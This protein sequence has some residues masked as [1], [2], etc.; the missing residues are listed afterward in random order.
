MSKDIDLG[1]VF[2]PKVISDFMVNLFSDID[3][4][5]KVVLDPCF[6][7]GIFIKSLINKGFTKIRGYEI[8]TNLYRVF[9]KE[10]GDFK[11][12]KTF[13]TDF[14][15]NNNDDYYDCVVMNPPY[16]RHE[17]I[18]DLSQFG[19]TKD[20][21]RRLKIFEDL[22]SSS[23]IYM[24]FILKALSILKDNGEL[25]VIMP[26]TWIKNQHN[27]FLKSIKKHG[28]IKHM[29]FIRGSVF[30]KDALVSVSILKI[31]KTSNNYDL[32]ETK[33]EHF[34]YENNKLLQIEKI[35]Y[36]DPGDQ[37]HCS[38]EDFTFIR[39]GITT[40][41]N[42]FFFNAPLDGKSYRNMVVSPKNIVGFKTTYKS[43]SKFLYLSKT[44]KASSEVSEYL[45]ISKDE[46]LKIKKPKTIYDYIVKGRD[47]PDFSIFDK[48]CIGIIF[49]YM[50][51]D[52][53]RF[54][55]NNKFLVRDNFYIISSNRIDSYLL[56]A[57]LNNY[58][59][60]YRLE[61]RG[62]SY[63]GAMLKLQ[64][65]DLAKLKIINPNM[66]NEEDKT[67]LV[68]YGKDLVKTSSTNFIDKISRILEKYEET[69]FYEIKQN[70]SNIKSQRLGKDDNYES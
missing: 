49:N 55:L 14:L 59:T 67:D 47:W 69:K 18:D 29:Y 26:D 57:L 66:I 24:Y 41:Y 63:G 61:L 36:N 12:L 40:G 15:F 54:I 30:G 51:R 9:T 58:Y 65:Y 50:V 62:K 23:N 48:N 2:T 68:N 46:I 21:L 43:T 28:F 3:K 16:I 39:R 4:N 64:K 33:I 56:L 45:E 13:N 70:L 53:M 32:T 37:N 11:D 52:N 8:D 19:I 7:E 27:Y 20:K 25:V 22:A 10:Y 1:Q 42:S 35:D 6:G 5:N 17:K 60:Y 44:S 31:I 38:L 34:E